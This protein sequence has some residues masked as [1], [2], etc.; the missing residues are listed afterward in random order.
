MDIA[1]RALVFDCRGESLVGV[2]SMHA[3]DRASTGVLII[4]GGPQYRVGSHR[5]FVRLARFMAGQGVP[6]MRFDYRGMGDATGEQRN[7]ATVN[8]DV[9]AAIE[10]FVAAV[11]GLE[12]VVLWGLCD[13]ASA[14]CLA[15]GECPRVAGAVL[16]NPWVRTEAGK[17]SVM[18]RHY[19]L[20]RL[21]D[22]RFWR[23]L[24]RGDVKLL[25]SASSLASTVAGVRG[26]GKPARALAPHAPVAQSRPP[27]LAD[28]PRLPQRMLEA[29][30]RTDVPIAVALSGRDFVAREFEQL[31]ERER[32]WRSLM[33]GARVTVQR[34]EQAD[35]TFS[36]A[37]DAAAVEQFTLA[38][39][40]AQGLL[41]GD[42]AVQEH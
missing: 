37:V 19:Y 24:L 25:R 9:R 5:H 2:V 27:H 31:V 30:A 3:R 8:D 1:E 6:C 38:W 23:K 20:R 10:A 32:T 28:V 41:Q 12:R 35:H 11:P 16:L 4:V 40:N 26:G 13:G 34:F 21:L 14:A 7:F 39:L 17:A 42:A 15:L 33:G 22:G 36:R 18:L 29:L